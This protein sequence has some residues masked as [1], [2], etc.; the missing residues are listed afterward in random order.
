MP[1]EALLNEPDGDFIYPV[2]ILHTA[3]ADLALQWAA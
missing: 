1:T 2:W 3:V